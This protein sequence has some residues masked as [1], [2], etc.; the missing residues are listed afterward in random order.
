VFDDTQID[1][2]V[3]NVENELKTIKLAI[4][5]LNHQNEKIIDIMDNIQFQLQ[6]QKGF[7][8]GIKQVGVSTLTFLS[9]ITGALIYAVDH[10]FK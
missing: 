6:N 3:Y 9:I 8:N 4:N 7:M 5:R 10:V 2:R 1:R